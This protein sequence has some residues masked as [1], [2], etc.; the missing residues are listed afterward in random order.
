M[1]RCDSIETA[2]IRIRETN[3]AVIEHLHLDAPFVNGTMVITT[4]GKEVRRSC[5]T[6]LGSM[7]DVRCID[8]AGAIAPREAATA[9][10][11]VEKAA[12]RCRN[13]AGLAPDVQRFT[14]LV[15]DDTDD[16]RVT[17]KTPRRLRGDRRS[18][19]EL[20]APSLLV[21]ERLRGDVHVDE[22]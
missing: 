21:S 7:L 4:Q 14:V 12:Q 10:S 9:I 13:R 11:G 2:P 16:A 5:L 8:P 19:L 20:A 3:S 1:L 15:F 22:S 17:R 18:F 6:A